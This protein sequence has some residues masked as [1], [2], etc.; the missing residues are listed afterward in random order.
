VPA[1]ASDSIYCELLGQL[2][3]HAGMTGKTGMIVGLYNGEYVHLP[4]KMVAF[5]R[6]VDIGG[7]L[8][9]R[10]LEATGQPVSMKN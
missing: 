4:L 3:V 6:K 2:A 8:W 7:N 9:A 10:V 1:N 5:R